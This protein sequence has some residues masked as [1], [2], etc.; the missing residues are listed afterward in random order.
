MGS[1]NVGNTGSFV[2]IQLNGFESG[3]IIQLLTKNIG[4]MAHQQLERTDQLTVYLTG[5]VTVEKADTD[6]LILM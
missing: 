5:K 3:E 2:H 6:N 1:E 4:H